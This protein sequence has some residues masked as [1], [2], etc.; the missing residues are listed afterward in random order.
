MRNGRP[1]GPL[2]VCDVS[3]PLSPCGTPAAYERH[4][5]RNEPV[6][7]ACR[8][9]ARER[10]LERRLAEVGRQIAAKTAL[11]AAAGDGAPEPTDKLREARWTMLQLRAAL[12]VAPPSA[13][14]SIARAY[15][16]AVDAVV[17]L[18]AP[19]KQTSLVD[20]L[21]AA[22]EARLARGSE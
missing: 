6:D 10:A 5:R 21:A 20:Q 16:A 8:A 17:A 2:S 4:R 14:A 11:L 9:A 15:L 1:T 22:R 7:D 13:A 18:E 3:R 19:K 12:E